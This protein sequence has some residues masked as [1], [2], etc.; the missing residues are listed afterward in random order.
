VREAH[1]HC[2]VVMQTFGGEDHRG[3][4]TRG[5]HPSGR[6]S[7]MLPTAAARTAYWHLGEETLVRQVTQVVKRSGS[8]QL[9]AAADRYGIGEGQHGLVPGLEPRARAAAMHS[10]GKRM[11]EVDGA[12]RTFAWL[13][14]DGN[15]VRMLAM[16]PEDQQHKVLDMRTVAEQVQEAGADEVLLTSETWLAS[17]VG[18]DDSRFELRAGERED[19]TEALATHLLRRDG[20]HGAW[21]TPFGRNDEGAVVLGETAPQESP[22]ESP[23]FAPILAVWRQWPSL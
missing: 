2:G 17:V 14:R 10:L 1:E 20:G 6:L 3:P 19:R 12:H 16:D 21:I 13:Y 8:E 23:L 7:C 11:L 18:R 22:R 5:P 9:Q 4:Q 15:Q